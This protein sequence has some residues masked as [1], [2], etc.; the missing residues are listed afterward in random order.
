M[1]GAAIPGGSLTH[2]ASVGPKDHAHSHMTRDPAVIYAIDS[3]DRIV[4]VNPAWSAAA[5][6]AGM[7]G[8]AAPQVVGQSLWGFVGDPATRH[9]Y[10]AMLSRIRAGG[11]PMI[12]GFRCDTPVLRRLMEM[13]VT[14][15]ADGTVSFTVRLVA[16]QARPPV[17]LLEAGAPRGGSLIRM[18]GWCKRL[19]LPTG[20]WVEVEEALHALDILDR[21]PLPSISHGICPDCEG[22]IMTELARGPGTGNEE[23]RLGTL[24]PP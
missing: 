18:C 21:T 9:L 8:L 11:P 2:R 19:P 3:G 14:G 16:A 7:P 15:E 13:R 20:R 17:A 1:P 12:F 4:R 23:I 5:E 6:E 22:T 24:P 10:T